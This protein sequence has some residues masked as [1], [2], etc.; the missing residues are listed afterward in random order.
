MKNLISDEELMNDRL[1]ILVIEKEKSSFQS[2]L[3]IPRL[4]CGTVQPT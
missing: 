3:V 4:L 1:K 2:E